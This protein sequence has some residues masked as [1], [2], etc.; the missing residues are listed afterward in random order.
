MRNLKVRAKLFVGFLIVAATGIL[1]GSVGIISLLT[2]RSHS[3]DI[4]LLQHTGNGATAVLNA[5][6]A[7]RHNLTEAV[8]TGDDFTGATDPAVCALGRWLGSSEAAAVTDHVVLDLLRQINAPHNFIHTES[9]AV[10]A[11]LQVG[12]I[13]EARERVLE[14]ILPSTQEVISLLSQIEDRF[15]GLVDDGNAEILDLENT[16]II[17]LALF[18]AVAAVCSVL[19][20]LY[21]SGMITKPLAPLNA[22]MAKA[23]T[24]GDITLTDTDREI[25]GK[26]A[27]AND[28]IGKTIQNC[29]A[30]VAHVT[31]IAEELAS[32]A[33]GDLTADIRCLSSGD[34]LG[35]SLQKTVGSLNEMFG[36]IA[37]STAQ[38]SS[39]SKQVADGAQSLAQGS[40][41]QAAAVEELSSSISEIANKTKDNAKM[42]E[43]AANLAKS[44]K[45]KAENGSRQ[46]GEMTEAVKEINLASQNI[47]KVIKVIDDIA[48]QTNILALNAAVEAARAGQHGKGF[49]VV[50]EE[51]RNLAA[52]SA[53]AA[54]ETGGMIA[55]SMA[56]AEL[57]ARIA[58]D[59]AASLAEIV[60]GINESSHIVHEIAKSSEE[61]SAGI[62]QIN[63]GIDQVAI[64]IQQNSAT[65]EESAAASEEMN[66]QSDLLQQLTAQFKLRRGTAKVPHSAERKLSIGSGDYGKY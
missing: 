5:H 18:M 62:G 55:D 63:Q 44:I 11:H 52:K 25:I 2:I 38:V 46:M 20:T 48:F 57:G 3:E 34:V 14:V 16:A 56:K 43:Q 50:A 41:E 12:E 59:T 21:I 28:E 6:Y 15:D 64:V 39:G 26:C 47:S 8:L 9:R 49:A 40:T 66:G 33:D 7:W 22:F 60:S 54:K 1:L 4:I 10:A 31:Q 13:E 37:N 32:V 36:E 42:A 17:I 45:S 29:A 24:T 23:G 51:V 61:Q 65:A 27:K 35:T 30:F 19:L 53:E 58:E